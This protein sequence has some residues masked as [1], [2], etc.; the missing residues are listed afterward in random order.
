MLNYLALEVSLLGDHLLLSTYNHTYMRDK[1]WLFS[2]KLCY[3]FL[4][5]NKLVIFLSYLVRT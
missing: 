2:V 5:R 4:S 1:L 3:I